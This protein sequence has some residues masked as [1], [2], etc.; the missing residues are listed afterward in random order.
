[1]KSINESKWALNLIFKL[2]FIFSCRINF[3]ISGKELLLADWNHHQPEPQRDG[4]TDYEPGDRTTLPLFA[5]TSPFP[6]VPHRFPKCP[7]KSHLPA[8][9]HLPGW[10]KQPGEAAGE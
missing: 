9:T 7:A 6:A 4:V 8:S 2:I 10:P 5:Q 3:V 1:M